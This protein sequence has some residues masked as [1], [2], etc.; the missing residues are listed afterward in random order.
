MGGVQQV[1]IIMVYSVLRCPHFRG[2]LIEG[3]QCMYMSVI[4]S[5][6]RHRV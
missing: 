6:I 5:F 2:V 1:E 4:M 3:L